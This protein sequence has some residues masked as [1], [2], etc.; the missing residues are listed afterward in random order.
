M[1]NNRLPTDTFVE[2][3]LIHIEHSIRINEPHDFVSGIIADLHE[4][5]ATTDSPRERYRIITRANSLYST[6]GW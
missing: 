4:R 2:D 1:N 3:M 5:L 6:R